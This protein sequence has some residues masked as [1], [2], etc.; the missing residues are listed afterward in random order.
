MLQRPSHV[1][2]GI[3]R[4]EVINVT[5]KTNSIL[6]ILYK[7]ASSISQTV[8]LFSEEY[9]DVQRIPSWPTPESYY[10][11]SGNKDF[12]FD[13]NIIHDATSYKV[14]VVW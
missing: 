5:H 13:N 10:S 11:Q 1:Q 8:G 7:N 12:F 14:A 9:S 6:S 2:F 3:E 4:M